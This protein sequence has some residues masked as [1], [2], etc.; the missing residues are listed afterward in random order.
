MRWLCLTIALFLGGCAVMGFEQKTPPPYPQSPQPSIRLMESAAQT[1]D[2]VK[3]QVGEAARGTPALTPAARSA[4][5]VSA[6][7]GAPAH[8]IASTQ[9]AEKACGTLEREMLRQ[10]GLE[11]DYAER[12]EA[13]RGTPVPAGWRMTGTPQGLI[14]LGIG[15]LVVIGAGAWVLSRI[16]GKL[17]KL[18][19]ELIGGKNHA[20]TK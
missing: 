2:W 3:E 16:S 5:A 4:R 1:A 13:Y 18:F 11:A 19:N 10:R 15:L 9:E 7:V 17:G 14:W 6:Y 20:G 12:V 8:P